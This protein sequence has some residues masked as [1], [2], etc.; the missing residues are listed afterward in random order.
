[1]SRGH[2]GGPELQSACAAPA[3]RALRVCVWP[4]QGARTRDS[5]ARAAGGRRPGPEPQEPRACEAGSPGS[6]GQPRSRPPSWQEPPRSRPRVSCSSRPWDAAGAERLPGPG[7]CQDSVTPTPAQRRQL[8]RRENL[9][10]AFASNSFRCA[11]FAEPPRV[12]FC[13]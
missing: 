12:S 1:M 8:L 11:S 2:V 9:D 5:S 7:L 6:L 3:S 4:P 10:S 13:T